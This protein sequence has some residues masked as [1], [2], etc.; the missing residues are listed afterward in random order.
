S[1]LAKAKLGEKS[2]Y[3]ICW[4]SLNSLFIDGDGMRNNSRKSQKFLSMSCNRLQKENPTC[5]S[6][7][8]DVENNTIH[9]IGKKKIINQ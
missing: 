2:F 4:F 3:Y 5:S 1:E 8:E 6:T 9:P 7:L